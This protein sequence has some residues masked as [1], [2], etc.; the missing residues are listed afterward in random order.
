LP[1]NTCTSGV[2]LPPGSSCTVDVTFNPTATEERTG[3][4]TFSDNASPA[5]QTVD[6]KGAG[7]NTFHQCDGNGG[8]S[9]SV[10][11]CFDNVNNLSET[12]CKQPPYIWT[13][14]WGCALTSTGTLLTALNGSA[15][16]TTLDTFLMGDTTPLGYSPAGSGYLNWCAVPGFMQ[17]TVQ[18]V[19]WSAQ[20]S[21]TINGYLT[22]HVVKKQDAVVLQL[23]FTNDGLSCLGTDKNNNA[24]TPTSQ[25]TATCY[26]ETHYI[27]VL[28]P[29][30]NTDS[31]WNVF[32]PAWTWTTSTPQNALTLSGH[33][34]GFIDSN[35]NNVRFLIRSARTYS[36]SGVPS[37]V[38]L[39]ANSPVELLVTDPEGRQLGY[40]PSGQD[41]FQIPLGGYV[42]DFLIGD[43]NGTST[44]TG[45]GEASGIK[46][47]SFPNPLDGTYTV[48]V[49]GT[50]SGPYTLQFEGVT[51]DGSPQETTVTGTTAQGAVA[52][53]QISYASAPGSLFTVTKVPIGPQATLS[54]SQLTFAGQMVNSTSTAQGVTLSNTGDSTLNISGVTTSAGFAES[55]T[56]GAS[57]AAGA[58]CTIS[59]TFTPSAAGARTGTLTFADNAANSPQSVNLSGEGEDFSLGAQTTSQSVSPGVTA[60]YALVLTPEGG[61]N[62]AIGLTCSGAPSN[63]TC[64]VTPASV[65]LDGTNNAAVGLK[66]TTTAAAMVAPGDPGNFAPPSGSLP[67]AG[68]LALFNL[69]GMIVVVRISRK[70]F[71]FKRVVPFATLALLVTLWAACGGGSSP[72]SSTSNGTPPG[73]YTLTVTGA[74]GSLSHSTQVTLKVQ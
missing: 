17:N 66:V 51:T 26:P 53:Y 14:K 5:T 8:A 35:G 24:C 7:V 41:V 60:S 44:G 42:R 23:C 71:R 6:L 21:S 37:Q 34:A 27:A 25:N 55:N 45:P 36:R 38:C 63:S 31:D 64:T 19:D 58:S 61:F 43:D 62:Q 39:R 57:V 68:W 32:D 52:T 22:D 20:N 69:L 28:G 29:T 3:T 10:P 65:I 54:V 56:C 13:C 47:A 30:D 50:A 18:L 4:L 46:T 11:A 2:S 16:P 9:T 49:T 70:D 15:T 12:A 59:V 1:N 72:S 48:K 67:L 74:S 33:L 40:V 73:T